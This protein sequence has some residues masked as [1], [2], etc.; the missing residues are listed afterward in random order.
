MQRAPGFLLLALSLS[1]AWAAP[2]PGASPAS[3]DLV[4]APSLPLATPQQLTEQLQPGQT[5][6]LRD[7]VY[8]GQP[9]AGDPTGQREVRLDAP[10][11]VLRSYPGERATIIGRIYVS[12]TADGSVVE[13]LTLDGQNAKGSPSPSIDDSDVVFRGNDISNGHTAI[14]FGLG[15]PG[16]GQAVNVQILDNRIH[17][18]GKLP[19]ANHDHGIYVVWGDRTLIRGNLIYDN[20]DRGIQLYPDAHDTL[21][22]GNVIAGNGQGIV[23]GGNEV[24][25]STN[26]IAR[27]NVISDS[28]NRF[29]VESSWGLAIGTGNYALSNCV[30]SAQSGYLSGLPQGSGILDHQIG[31]EAHDNVVANPGFGDIASGDLRVHN[32]R[33]A[34]MLEVGKSPRVIAKLKR[35]GPVAVGKA[36]SARRVFVKGSGKKARVRPDGSFR[37]KLRPGKKA[38]IAAAGMEPSRTLKPGG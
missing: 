22:V 27:Y 32:R 8:L 15:Q 9:L 38:R 17:G 7:G 33:C 20:A 21:V 26:N 31:F 29:N 18:C 12:P 37:I 2:A 28:Q 3:C 19:A 30:W 16:F 13:N 34:R 35:G 25:T 23:F 36:P 1:A 6:C 4:A 14:C 24:S 5:G 10:G 11:S